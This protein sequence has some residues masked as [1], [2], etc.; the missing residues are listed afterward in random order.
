MSL[1]V[2][3][4]LMRGDE[5][6]KLVEPH[7]VRL[8]PDIHGSSAVSGSTEG[9]AVGN[10]NKTMESISAYMVRGQ[11]R[12]FKL[13]F[14]RPREDSKSLKA[15]NMPSPTGSAPSAPASA[16]ASASTRSDAGYEEVPLGIAR[17]ACEKCT[18][19]KRK[20]DKT[21][22]TCGR[23]KRYAQVPVVLQRLR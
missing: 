23:C 8:A 13:P 18:R 12:L 3:G 4:E 14:L 5:L 6:T 16:S 19:S 22:P 15:P 2:A 20:C 10:R 21:T 7:R 11:S 17:R 9:G 1:R